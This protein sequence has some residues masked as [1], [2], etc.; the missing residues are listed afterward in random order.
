SPDDV[1]GVALHVYCMRPL[2]DLPFLR[3]TFPDIPGYRLLEKVGK[4]F[5]GPVYKARQTAT[6]QS[7]AIKVVS[8]GQTRT[9]GLPRHLEDEFQTVSTLIHPNIVQVVEF[10]T[11]QTDAYLVM[12]YVEGTSLARQLKRVG[13]FAADGAVHMIGE[14]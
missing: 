7:V 8:S 6:G 13:R 11:T 9:G 3:P 10:G 5:N 14:L 12:E 2:M 4:A 1:S